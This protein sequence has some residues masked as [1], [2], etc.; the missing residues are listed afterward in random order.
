MT[1]LRIRGARPADAADISGLLRELSTFFLASLEDEHGRRY[2]ADTSPGRIREAIARPDHRFFVAE[3]AGGAFAG[4]IETR[5]SHVVRFFVAPAHQRQGVGN[6]LWN[7]ALAAMRGGGATPDVTVRASVFAVPIYGRL[8]F[9]ITGERT[10][11]HGVTYVPM[12][13]PGSPAPAAPK[14]SR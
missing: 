7:H 4:F 2:L 9:E 13:L 11:E 12:V 8:G 1:S 5:G 14:G 3:A 6:L 10:T